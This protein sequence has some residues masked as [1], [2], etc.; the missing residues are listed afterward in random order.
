MF[1]KRSV[2]SYMIIVNKALHR[3][4][5]HVRT[6]EKKYPQAWKQLAHFRAL[7]GSSD[8]QW[9]AWC[10]VPLAGAYAIVTGGSNIPPSEEAV[11]DI[12]RISGL[13]AWRLS[14]G[15]YQFDPDLF[16]AVW[17]TSL[18]NKLPVEVLFALPEYC[19]YVL[20][21]EPQVMFHE[22][23]R[24]IFV[25]LEYDANS[26]IPELRLL[27]DCESG[28]LLPQMLHLGRSSILDNLRDTIDEINKHAPIDIDTSILSDASLSG[29]YQEWEHALG[30]VLYLCSINVD[31]KDQAGQKLAPRRP[32]PTK[33]KTGWRIFPP[34][35]PTLWLV[36]K[37]IGEQIR[38]QQVIQERHY[39][40]ERWSPKP[41]IRRAHWHSYWTGSRKDPQERKLVLRWIFPI[42]VGTGSTD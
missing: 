3:I 28:N 6:I 2:R 35:K 7:R 16:D 41:H 15:I 4:Q 25:S 33:T 22:K 1:S 39:A 9:P 27:L 29:L 26:T 19:L 8:F 18:D 42:L 40:E 23:V 17:N 12:A 14:Q 21:P 20:F 11:A 36:G 13:G 38:E 5:D 34:D 10:Y 24:G 37:D 31:I 32:R 30:L